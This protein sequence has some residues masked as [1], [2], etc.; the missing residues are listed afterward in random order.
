[1]SNSRIEVPKPVSKRTV[2]KGAVFNV[3]ESNIRE[4]DSEYIRETITHNGSAV[5]VPLTKKN[6]VFLV[7]QYRHSAG[8]YL[9]ELP[10]GS[11]EDG[12]T[13]EEC[14]VREVEEEIGMKPGKIEKLTEFFVSPGFLDEKIHVFLATELT[15]TKQNLDEDE[16]ISVINLSL[17][18]AIEKVRSNEIEDAKTMLGLTFAEMTIRQ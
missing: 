5:I 16:N 17:K 7:E 12:E 1:M 9:L 4:G 11:I 13:A 10:A 18:E 15:K 6:E 8:R 2:F 14:A 3:V